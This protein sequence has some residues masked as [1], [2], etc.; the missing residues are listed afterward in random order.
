MTAMYKVVSDNNDSLDV[1]ITR[2]PSGELAVRL[3]V[4]NREPIRVKNTISVLVQGY[5]PDTLFILANIK[6][7]LDEMVRTACLN[8]QIR[9]FMPY[10]PHARYDRHIVDGDAFALRVFADMMNTLNFDR[11]MTVDAHSEMTC[12]LMRRTEERPQ[13]EHAVLMVNKFNINCDV[14]VAPDAGA[15]KKIFKV[16]QHL[17]KPV[18]TMTKTRDVK[19][20]N[21][22]GM[23]MM[24]EL[25]PNARCL[26]IDDLCDGGRTFIEAAKVLRGIGASSVDLMVTH[27]IFSAG[28]NN[29]L[30]NGIDHVYCTDSF[31][32]LDTVGWNGM[33]NQYNFF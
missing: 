31:K 11:I 24:D 8:C 21:I 16:A 3:D 17:N 5:E 30:D 9:L 10:M 2:F 6:D 18:V 4:E 7:A 15:Q 33:V 12:G 26:I 14:L 1:I 29:L 19:T 27:G 23:L 28:L 32:T 22:T 25:P 20:G 13:W